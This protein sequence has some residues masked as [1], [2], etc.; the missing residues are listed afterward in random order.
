MTAALATVLN[1]QAVPCDKNTLGDQIVELSKASEAMD[2]SKTA[3]EIV[4]SG[5]SLL[6][7]ASKA[8]TTA[9]AFT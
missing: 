5:E 8:S 7:L 4:V 9:I 6:R 1:A 3:K 2:S